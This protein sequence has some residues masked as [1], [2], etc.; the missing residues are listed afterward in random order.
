MGESQTVNIEDDVKKVREILEK[1]RNETI[2]VTDSQQILQGIITVGDFSRKADDVRNIAELMNKNHLKI[3]EPTDEKN[4]ATSVEQTARE[5]FFQNRARAQIREIPVVSNEGKLLYIIKKIKPAYERTFFEISDICNAKC[6][7]CKKGKN[8]KSGNFVAQPQG[9]RKFVDLKEFKKSIEYMLSNSF[10]DSDTIIRL[11]RRGEPFLHP[12]FKEIVY[13]LDELEVPFWLST[14]ASNPIRF[15]EGDNRVLKHLRGLEFSVSGFSQES[16]GRIHG[17]DLDMIKK[18]IIS[19]TR[20]YRQAGF[21]G[22]AILRFHM[23]QFNLNEIKTAIEFAKN[24]DMEISIYTAHFNDQDEFRKYV[25]NELGYAELKLAGEELLL[26]AI[27][28]RLKEYH[29]LYKGENK[30]YC[31]ELDILSIDENC[32]VVTCCGD[33]ADVYMKIYDVET[34]DEINSWRES[35]KLCKE[36]IGSGMTYTAHNPFTYQDMFGETI[37]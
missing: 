12:N 7:Y 13:C 10:I 4:K 11:Y 22:H 31:P 14:N 3:E 9:K 21:S 26:Y 5:V 19:I 25:K 23:Y 37:S 15:D 28:K 18:N 29:D 30:Y 36:C 17:F 8:N 2:F 24:N 34:V 27:N 1:D 20:N 33:S 35:S 16:L 32:N 6:T